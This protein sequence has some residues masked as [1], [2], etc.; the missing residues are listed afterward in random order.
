MG[1]WT[2]TPASGA[3][4]SSIFWG[5]VTRAEENNEQH[6]E[7]QGTGPDGDLFTIAVPYGIWPP[8]EMVCGPSRY[9]LSHSSLSPTCRHRSRW[10]RVHR[11]L[12]TSF[13]HLPCL[14]L[15]LRLSHDLNQILCALESPLNISEQKFWFWFLLLLFELLLHWKPPS[16][17][18]F[19]ILS[20]KQISS[21]GRVEGREQRAEGRG[22]N[23]AF[24]N[25]THHPAQGYIH[26]S[27]ALCSKQ[28]PTMN[29]ETDTTL[30]LSKSCHWKDPQRLCFK[31]SR[32]QSLERLDTARRMGTESWFS[33]LL[34]SS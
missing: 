12:F 29:E 17:F 10:T 21:P 9:I 32:N 11:L 4:G 23:P 20:K 5:L 31:E 1:V 3:W 30:E 27:S 6:M 26:S 24:C 13:L 15:I 33:Y 18:C 16:S 34:T 2:V 19:P 28:E 25:P 14:C 7:E 22:Q 8:R